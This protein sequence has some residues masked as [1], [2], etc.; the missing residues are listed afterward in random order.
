M[1]HFFI[2]FFFFFFFF[3]VCFFCLFFF[4][5]FFFFFQIRGLDFSC[6]LHILA[7]NIDCGYSLE[8][9]LAGKN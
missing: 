3:F 1:N 6:R 5:F 2:F 7:Q 4:F 9:L 8:P